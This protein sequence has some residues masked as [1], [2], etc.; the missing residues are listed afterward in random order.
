MDIYRIASE[1]RD[2][3][4]PAISEKKKFKQTKTTMDI[5]IEKGRE[6]DESVSQLGNPL[7]PYIIILPTPSHVLPGTRTNIRPQVVLVW[8]CFF[9]FFSLFLF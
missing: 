9:Y 1:P 2:I 5:G 6:I 8:K 7:L 3:I 4:G